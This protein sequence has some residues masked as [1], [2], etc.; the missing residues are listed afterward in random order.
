MVLDDLALFVDD[1]VEQIDPLY[2]FEL[3]FGEHFFKQDFGR[4]RNV[5]YVLGNLQLHFL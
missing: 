1:E 2:S 3:V 5:V 4:V